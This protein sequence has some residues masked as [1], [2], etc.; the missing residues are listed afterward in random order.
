[1]KVMSKPTERR[2]PDATRAK[3]AP[4]DVVAELISG[5]RR[6][7]PDLDPRAMAVVGRILTL[8]RRLEGRANRAVKGFALD[9]SELDVLATLRRRGAP[10]SLSPSELAR[11][12]LITSGA[13]TACLDRL[14][15]RGLIE[16]RPHEGDRRRLRVVLT[17]RGRDL[18]DAAIGE[19]FREADEAL[20]CLSAAERRQLANLLARLLAG[21]PN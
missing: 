15:E 1:M 21:L 18:I 9:Y 13:M 16:R 7:R 12:V 5:W 6:E 17:A 14:E 20:A 3:A 4:A 19:R 11:S 10:Y 8:G 2:V